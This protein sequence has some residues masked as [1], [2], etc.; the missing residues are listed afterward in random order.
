MVG[1]PLPIRDDIIYD[2]FIAAVHAHTFVIEEQD[3][4]FI[5][6]LSTYVEGI[7]DVWMLFYIPRSRAQ[8]SL[9]EAMDSDVD[10]TTEDEAAGRKIYAELGIRNLGI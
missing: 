9:A 4:L 8:C 6:H 5:F 3:I 2:L 10:T 7:I 1:L